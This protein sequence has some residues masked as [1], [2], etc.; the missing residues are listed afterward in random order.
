MLIIPKSIDAKDTLRDA[1]LSLNQ[2]GDE[3]LS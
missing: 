2:S 3:L 1:G